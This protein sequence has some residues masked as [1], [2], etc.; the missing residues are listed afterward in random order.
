M[1]SQDETNNSVLTGEPIAETPLLD[2]MRDAMA[3]MIQAGG[4]VTLFGVETALGALAL[5]A[6]DVLARDGKISVD[7]KDGG[8]TLTW[9]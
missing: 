3:T 6:I 4:K 8:I 7:G 1:T 5:R 9:Q 2:A